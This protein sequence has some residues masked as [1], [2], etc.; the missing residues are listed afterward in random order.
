MMIFGDFGSEFYMY[1]DLPDYLKCKGCS[2]EFRAVIGWCPK[3]GSK[4]TKKIKIDKVES[5]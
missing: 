3:C 5:K 1:C 2:H 4:D